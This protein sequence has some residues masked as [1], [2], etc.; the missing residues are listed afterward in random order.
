MPSERMYE[1]LL[2]QMYR[3]QAGEAERVRFIRERDA[4]WRVERVVEQPDGD[5]GWRETGREELAEFVING[6]HRAPKQIVD[7]QR[8]P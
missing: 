4:P 6:E 3:T 2:S 1:T 8:G 7:A 5:G